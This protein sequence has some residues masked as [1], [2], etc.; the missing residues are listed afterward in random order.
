MGG[1]LAGAARVQAMDNEFL[2]EGFDPKDI[3]RSI[4]KEIYTHINR[5]RCIREQVPDEFTPDVDKRFNTKLK[6]YN[7]RDKNIYLVVNRSKKSCPIDDGIYKQLKSDLP[8]LQVIFHE[9]DQTGQA[10]N[11]DEIELDATLD[12][13]Y[14]S[15]KEL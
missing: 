11:V 12:F 15:D 5:K 1:R 3:V 7:K 2:E 13:F 6:I 10:F 4:K 9:S 14:D 8:D